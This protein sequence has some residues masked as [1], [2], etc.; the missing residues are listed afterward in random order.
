V[1]SWC[2][3]WSQELGSL[4][5]IGMDVNCFK[6]IGRVSNLVRREFMSSSWWSHEISQ[7]RLE[8]MSL[9]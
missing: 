9:I 7:A 8:L 4:G 3:G 6:M 1:S 2:E 5:D